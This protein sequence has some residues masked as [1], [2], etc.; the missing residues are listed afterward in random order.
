MYGVNIMD[1]RNGVD[2]E[3]LKIFYGVGTEHEL[4]AAMDRHIEKLQA[5]VRQ[6]MPAEPAVRRVREG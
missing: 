6:F 1:D 3:R 2:I 4:I 5:K